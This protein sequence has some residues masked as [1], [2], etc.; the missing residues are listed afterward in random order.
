MPT[1]PR[2]EVVFLVPAE[3]RAGHM[4]WL[5]CLGI[6][7]WWEMDVGSLPVH[8]VISRSAPNKFDTS[9]QDQEHNPAVLQ[10]VKNGTSKNNWFYIP[11]HFKGCGVP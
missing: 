6:P 1:L 10:P 9:H 4:I 11:G 3:H 2:K 7:D 5:K 8:R